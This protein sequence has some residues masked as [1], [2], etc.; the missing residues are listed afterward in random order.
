MFIDSLKVS[1]KA[2]RLYFGVSLVAV[3][4]A[5]AVTMKETNDSMKLLLNK[6]K[7]KEYERNVCGNFKVIA[8][9]LGIQFGYTRHC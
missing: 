6:I 1:M 9:F 3:S 7:F 8:L 4:F 5:H 2:V